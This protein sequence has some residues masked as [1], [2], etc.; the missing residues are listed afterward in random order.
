MS[1][2]GAET[3]RILGLDPGSRNTGYGLI[4]KTG[5]D[6]T[7]LEAG[8]LS[9]PARADFPQRLHDLYVR[10]CDLMARCRPQMIAV[11]DIFHAVNARTALKLAHARGVLILA[12]AQAELPVWAYPPATVK[13]TVVGD[14]AADKARVAWMVARLLPAAPAGMGRDA[15]DALAVA[16]C[17]AAHL[18]RS[19]L[20]A[21]AAVSASAAGRRPRS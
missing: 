10:T 15:S 20:V 4:E 11:E 14:G 12:A 2:P 6:L 7:Y 16:L 13:K 1:R 18:R 5:T 8:V 9:P 19:R 21:A 3:A 17:H